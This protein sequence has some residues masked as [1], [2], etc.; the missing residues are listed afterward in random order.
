MSGNGLRVISAGIP[1]FGAF[2]TGNTPKSFSAPLT[3]FCVAGPGRR[4]RARSATLSGTGIIQC[5]DRSSVV[6][7]ARATDEKRNRFRHQRHNAAVHRTALAR[8]DA[9]R[10]PPG[11]ITAQEATLAEVLL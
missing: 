7:A 4:G 6:S 11:A 9:A 5:G 1:D 2:L 10:C 8:A 3:R